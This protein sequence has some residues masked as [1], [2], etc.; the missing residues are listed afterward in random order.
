MKPISV[1]IEPISSK[2]E[3]KHD[4]KV[5]AKALMELTLSIGGMTCASCVSIIESVLQGEKGIVKVSVN[6]ATNTGTLRCVLL[7]V[8]FYADGVL[9]VTSHTTPPF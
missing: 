3:A 1:V 6:L 7:I 9:Q 5:E 4:K 8:C 2:S